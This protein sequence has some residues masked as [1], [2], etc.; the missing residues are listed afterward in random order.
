MIRQWD[1]LSNIIS[2]KRLNT[3]SRNDVF[4][5]VANVPKANIYE[6]L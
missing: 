4:L 6:L 1:L 3:M 5:G 2:I